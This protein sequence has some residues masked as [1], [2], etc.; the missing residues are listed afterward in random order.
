MKSE[1]YGVDEPSAQALLQRH[2]DL[3]GEIQAYKGDV[4]GLNSQA[5]KLIVSGISSLQVNSPTGN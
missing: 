2:R 3:C 5:E 4:Q 1:D